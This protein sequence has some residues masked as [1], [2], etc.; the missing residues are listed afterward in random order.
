[1]IQKMLVTTRDDVVYA[2]AS[3]LLSA[4]ALVRS[5]LTK[6]VRKLEAPHGFLER[7]PD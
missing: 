2:D 1:M 4:S 5:A 7:S 3:E 6:F